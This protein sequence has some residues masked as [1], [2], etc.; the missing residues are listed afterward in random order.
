MWPSQELHSKFN[1]QKA[2]GLS[3]NHQQTSPLCLCKNYL[4]RCRNSHLMCHLCRSQRLLPKHPHRRRH[5]STAIEI[6]RSVNTK[7]EMFLAVMRMFILFLFQNSQWKRKN[8]A[9]TS[10][11]KPLVNQVTSWPFPGDPRSC[12]VTDILADL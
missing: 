12:L 11:N 1:G 10:G 2:F 4:L 7:A 3:M 5:H 8:V 9:L 6:V